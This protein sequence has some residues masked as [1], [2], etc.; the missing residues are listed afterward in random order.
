MPNISDTESLSLSGKPRNTCAAPL[1][2]EYEAT[3]KLE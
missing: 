3:L 1:L 2:V